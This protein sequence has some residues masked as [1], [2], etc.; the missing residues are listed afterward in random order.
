MVQFD[1]HA[2]KQTVPEH[3]TNGKFPEPVFE[4]KQIGI[5][6]H[7][8]IFYSGKS[9]YVFFALICYSVACP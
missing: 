7:I 2:P 3:S 5:Y 8:C 4:N 1:V 6:A 9:N